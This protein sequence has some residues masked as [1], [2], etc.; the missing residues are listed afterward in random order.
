MPWLW[1]T[2]GCKMCA[3]VGKL[4]MLLWFTQLVKVQSRTS[5]ASVLVKILVLAARFSRFT[6]CAEAVLAWDRRTVKIFIFCQSGVYPR[7]FQPKR[8]LGESGSRQVP[9][10]APACLKFRSDALA[11]T[12]SRA[13]TRLCVFFRHVIGG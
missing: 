7:K 8:G 1:C 11:N 3:R 2:L 9:T 4:E 5:P 6:C 12:S 10:R 13:R